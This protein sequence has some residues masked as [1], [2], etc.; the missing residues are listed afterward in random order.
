MQ[1]NKKYFTFVLAQKARIKF[2]Y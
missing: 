2:F 1:I